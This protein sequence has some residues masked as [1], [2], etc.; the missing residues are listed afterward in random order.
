MENVSKYRN[1][2]V[3]VVEACCLNGVFGA[4]SCLVFSTSYCTFCFRN[5]INPE[6]SLP[7]HTKEAVNNMYHE[8][9]S[10]REM[11]IC[12]SHMTSFSDIPVIE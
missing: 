9:T 5:S 1:V 11:I 8:S 6:G 12:F 10:I 7:L 4:L 2:E 3:V